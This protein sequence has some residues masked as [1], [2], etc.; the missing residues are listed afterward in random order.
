LLDERKVP[1]DVNRAAHIQA[2][3]VAQHHAH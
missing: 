3:V 1:V 2:Q